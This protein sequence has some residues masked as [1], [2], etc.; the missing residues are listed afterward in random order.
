MADKSTAI[1]DLMRGYE[2]FRAPL[3]ALDDGAYGET[4]LGEWNLSQLLAHM[5]GWYREMTAAIARTSRGERPTPAGVDYSDADAWNATFATKAEAGRSA[6]ADFDAAYAG[7]LAAA[8]GLPE[9]LFGLAAEGGRPLIGNRLLQ[10]A[11]TGH[12]EEHQ[13]ELTAWIESR[14]E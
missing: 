4:W 13:A 8:R 1:H 9:E 5:A 11:G 7:Y 14:R 3:E 10:G 2:Q 6:L 12:F